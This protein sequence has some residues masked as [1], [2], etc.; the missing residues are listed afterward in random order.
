MDDLTKWKALALEHRG[1]TMALAGFVATMR[2]RPLS[3]RTRDVLREALVDAIGCGLYGLT[4]DWARIIHRFARDAGGPAE[5]ALWCGGTKVSAAHAA[6]A[7]G[8]AIHSFDFDD[9]SRAKIHP[10]AVVVPVVLALGERC[11]SPGHVLLAA[12]AAGYETM[13]RVSQAAN[14]GRARMRGWHLT[15]TCGTFAAAAAASVILGLDAAT[16][17]S[18]F[19]LAGT[20]SAGLWAFTADAAM[21]K[22]IHP[23]KAAQDGIN[24]AILAASGFQGPRY[25]LEAADGSFLF[26]MSDAP[27]PWMITEDLG[28]RWHSDE[29]CFKPHACCGSNHA[30]VDAAIELAE[31]EDLDV[32]GIE[33][34]VAGI[35]D[36]VRTQTG[37]DYRA[38]S[39]L[40]AQMSLQYNVAVALHDRQAYLEQFTPQRI[41]DPA[42]CET[43]RR[44]EI[45]VDPEIDR[46]YPE[47]YGGRL[48]ILLKN[49]RRLSKR[50]DYSRGMPENPMSGEEIERKFQSL[51]TAAV[52]RSSAEEI[53]ACARALFESPSS[54]P[55]AHLLAA[56]QRVEGD[57]SC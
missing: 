11:R 9:H 25:I 2:D 37:F 45:E 14:P 29:T 21:S 33:R 8:T 34:I 12:M 55:L 56:A 4:T 1:I 17:A 38:D 35:A 46:A 53:L 26:T 15:G 10:G 36:V 7:A 41:V 27:R 42:V 57:A 22:R 52:G 13:N 39:V 54:L 48:T 3:P 44:V 5:S 50:V 40:N 51:A 23:G 30:C 47:I 28:S 43:A 31:Q 20:Q 18:A 19:G 32:G 6:L 24:A 16:T 49:G